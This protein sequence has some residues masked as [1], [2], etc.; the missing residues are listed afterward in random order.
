[1]YTIITTIIIFIITIHT[2]TYTHVHTIAKV[3]YTDI[4]NFIDAFL[5]SQPFIVAS[6]EYYQSASINR[7]FSQILL[8]LLKFVIAS[9]TGLSR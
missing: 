6:H 9:W 8:S 3:K 4:R 5:Y 7:R 1:M 2:Y